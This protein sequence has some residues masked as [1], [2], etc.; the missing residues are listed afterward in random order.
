MKFLKI[1]RDYMEKWE[2]KN[3]SASQIEKSKTNQEREYQRDQF[4]RLMN[5][6]WMTRTDGSRENRDISG[7]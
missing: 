1:I 3:A 7:D 4:L 6:K 2:K 5:E